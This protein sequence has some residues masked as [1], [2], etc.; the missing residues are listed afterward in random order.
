MGLQI[1]DAN[2]RAF[3]Y[4]EFQNFAFSFLDFLFVSH[5]LLVYNIV[6]KTFQ[7]EVIKVQSH[8]KT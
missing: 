6:V 3:E 4:N 5:D 8:S 1:A 7:T 2:K